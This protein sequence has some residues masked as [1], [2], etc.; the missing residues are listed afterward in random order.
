MATAGSANAAGCATADDDLLLNSPSILE[1][2]SDQNPQVATFRE[3]AAAKRKYCSTD[4][5][6]DIEIEPRLCVRGGRLAEWVALPLVPFEGENFT[7]VSAKEPWI[8]QLTAGRVVTRELLAAVSKVK[9][10]IRTLVAAQ[11]AAAFNNSLQVAAKCRQALLLDQISL[12]DSDEEVENGIDGGK[13]GSQPVSDR[14]TA[15]TPRRRERRANPTTPMRPVTLLG[16]NFTVVYAKRMLFIEARADA[17][18]AVVRQLRVE[19]LPLTLREARARLATSEQAPGPPPAA[20]S[21]L[22]AGP[23]LSAGPTSSKHGASVGGSAAV[24]G[25]QGRIAFCNGRYYVCVVTANGKRTTFTKG[26]R[27]P[28][29]DHWGAP[30]AGP[31][32]QRA[33]AQVR[34]RAIRLW[35]QLDKSNRA[36][37]AA[38]DSN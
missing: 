28:V 2:R 30:L 16:V 7:R 20:G 4:D 23:P 33:V 37:F 25:D 17:V 24:A 27:V 29:V 9:T 11:A 31:N 22:P 10:H 21:P 12:E 26:L 32:Y 34:R 14:P 35:N 6:D 1:P 5:Y 13:D 38:D 36:R 15:E 8:C 18:T 19:L 3:N